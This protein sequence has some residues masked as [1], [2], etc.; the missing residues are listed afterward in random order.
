MIRAAILALALMP[1]AAG[2]A[3]RGDRR[4][5]F[6]CEFEGADVR[7]PVEGRLSGGKIVWIDKLGAEHPI[8]G[9][10]DEWR[11][12]CVPADGREYPVDTT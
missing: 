9:Q 2:C 10:P 6:W 11:W 1:A 5:K 4:P 7:A 8:T 12:S 3:E